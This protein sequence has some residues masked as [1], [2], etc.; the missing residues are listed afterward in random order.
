[1]KFRTLITEEAFYIIGYENAIH[2]AV[3]NWSA[4][5]KPEFA[6]FDQAREYREG[7]K[8]GLAFMSE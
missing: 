6:D 1:M 7:L 2:F 8:D 4:V 5:I 3:G